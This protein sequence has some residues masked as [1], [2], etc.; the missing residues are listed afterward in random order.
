MPDPVTGL[1][2][3]GN[4]V[5]GVIQQRD[6]TKAIRN[7][8]DAQTQ[9]GQDQIQFQRDALNQIRQDNAP[10]RD[11]D[12]QRQNVIGEVFGFNPVGDNMAKAAPTGQMTPQ[13]GARPLAYAGSEPISGPMSG[14]S[15]P[16]SADDD[17]SRY[18]GFDRETGLPMGGPER[19]IN[20]PPPRSTAPQ[21]DP[22]QS[23]QE[24]Q[25]TALDRFNDS[26]FGAIF[27]NNLGLETDSLDSALSGQGLALS[28]VR[29]NAKE[30]ARQRNF[31]SAFGNY[32]N[33]L[34]GFGTNSSAN[35]SNNNAQTNFANGAGA[36]AGNMG[37]AQANGAY[38]RSQANQQLYGSIAGGAGQGLGALFG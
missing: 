22:A 38:A 37:A 2:A 13:R 31:G 32:F 27:T 8:T 35:Q 1:A 11:M 3:G 18:T 14:F 16:M 17:P 15:N 21:M 9:A 36:A 10:F 23:R 19:L 5:S 4:I 24:R 26:P 34:S 25:G 29:S 6:Q 28:S 12:L 30:D 33:A 7:A 20:T